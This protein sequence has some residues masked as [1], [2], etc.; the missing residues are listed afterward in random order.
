MGKILGSWSGM[1]KYLEEEM[2]HPSL[3][4]MIRYDCTTY[5]G[6]DGCRVFTL[7]VEGK[8]FKRFSWETVNSFFIAHGYAEKTS[9]MSVPEYWQGFQALLSRVPMNQ[10]AEYTD[11]EFCAALTA[12]R[13][14]EIGESLMS[15][16]PI[17]NMFALLDRRTGIRALQR[18]QENMESRPK[19]LYALYDLRMRNLKH[20]GT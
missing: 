4:G 5:V 6:M 17:V 7:F 18:F 1:R 12:Y 3:R 13:N 2:L 16:N 11:G 14:Q 9:P 20:D 15:S 8:P 10:R 19:W